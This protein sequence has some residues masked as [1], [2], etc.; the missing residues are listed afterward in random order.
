VLLAAS[1]FL[2]FWIFLRDVYFHRFF[3]FQ[4]NLLVLGSHDTLNFL[5]KTGILWSDQKVV[6]PNNYFDRLLSPLNKQPHHN[7]SSFHYAF[8]QHRQVEIFFFKLKSEDLQTLCARISRPNASHLPIRALPRARETTGF[9]V[10][11]P[12]R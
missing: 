5:I 9:S 12:T 8:K 2:F 10:P 11:K 3:V 6:G 1:R 7:L 4:T